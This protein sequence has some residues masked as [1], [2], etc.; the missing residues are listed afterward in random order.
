MYICINAPCTVFADIH[1]HIYTH[2]HKLPINIHIHTCTREY[3]LVAQLC[4]TLCDSMDC[5]PPGPRLHGILQARILEWAAIHFSRG[6]SWPRYWAWVSCIA[7]GFFTIWATREA[8]VCT[9]IYVNIHKHIYT[10]KHMKIHE[11][12]FTQLRIHIYI[13]LNSLYWLRRPF[14]NRWLL[15]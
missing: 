12:I 10:A 5:S 8:H 13:F 2:I 4:P 3:V 6:S 9:Y 11:N 15:L 14:L 1:K 7:G